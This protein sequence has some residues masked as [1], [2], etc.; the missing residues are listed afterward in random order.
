MT[1]LVYHKLGFLFLTIQGILLRTALFQVYITTVH[2]CGKNITNGSSVIV[3]WFFF[4]LLYQAPPLLY[5]RILT[6]IL[7]YLFN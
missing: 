7:V 5:V 2:H 1:E 3:K 6:L 4:N